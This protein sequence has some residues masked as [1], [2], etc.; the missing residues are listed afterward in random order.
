MEAMTETAGPAPF[1]REH[2]PTTYERWAEEQG[3]PTVGG[4]YAHLNQL[5]L[6]PW[7]RLGGNATFVRLAGAR[8]GYT[9]G[10]V[11]EIPPGKHLNPQKHL[12]EETVWVLGGRGATT[13]WYDEDQKQTFE[14]Q[15]HSLFALPPNA[16]YQHFNLSGD[17]PARYYAVTDAPLV[18]DLFHNHDFVFNNDFRFSDRFGGDP[19]HF[20][21]RGN[22]LRDGDGPWETNFLPDL[23][24]FELKDAPGRGGGTS[25]QFELG[26]STLIAHSSEF[27]VGTYKK[28]HRHGSGASVIIV[29]GN[30]YTLHWKNPGEKDRGAYERVDWLPGTTFVPED[31]YLH[32]HFNTGQEPARYIAIRWGAGKYRFW[33]GFNQEFTMTSTDIKLGGNQIEYPDEEPWIYETYLEEC[34]KHGV[35]PDMERLFARDGRKL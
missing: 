27:P 23:G 6:K 21:G 32:Q 35:K 16:W 4:F 5:S 13:V 20:N 3:I 9:D 30:G 26:N 22:F 12:Y 2:R 8:Q 19:G 11:V 25:I 31:M 29:S 14:W 15:K 34:A 10:Q 17:E 1:G 7:E 18:M 28:A 33:P 24:K